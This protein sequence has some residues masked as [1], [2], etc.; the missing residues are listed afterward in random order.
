MPPVLN[1]WNSFLRILFFVALFFLGFFLFYNQAFNNY[2][3]DLPSHI[4]IAM[5]MFSGKT[6]VV[7]P[8]FHAVAFLFSKVLYTSIEYGAI[9]ALS[10][11]LVSLAIGISLVLRIFL[12]DL[13]SDTSMVVMTAIL[14]LV[15]AIYLPFFNENIYLGQGSP[16]VWHNPTIL[17]VKP[18]VLPCILLT[19]PF[20]SQRPSEAG[21]P[22]RFWLTSILLAVSTMMKPSF[23]LTFL[24]TIV[25]YL[26]LKKS[27]GRLDNNSKLLLLLL[28]SI[29]IIEL[30]LFGSIAKRSTAGFVIDFLGVWRLYSP[31]VFV[32]FLLATAFP[33]S[34][35]LFRMRQC[36]NNDYIVLSA[37]NLSV[38]YLLYMCFAEQGPRFAHGN[39]GWSRQIGLQIV[40]VFCAIEFFK[41]IKSNSSSSISGKIMISV[42]SILLSLH[43]ISGTYYLLRILAGNTYH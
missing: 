5:R 28:P 39:F 25:I 31:N 23:M 13:Y 12:R 30:Q 18:F 24:P 2:P 3:S 22:M 20:L 43:V 10:T 41:W 8:G 26:Y 21:V 15:S 36:L 19:L 38:G 4:N 27:S 42:S 32:S 1:L 14:L 6:I 16:N 35:M 34:I 7:H 37:I 9:M 17:A 40:F 33:L 11:A 29:L